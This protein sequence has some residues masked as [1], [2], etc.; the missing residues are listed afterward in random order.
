[1]LDIHD[2]LEGDIKVEL[3]DEQEL[4]VKGKIENK[5]NAS[6]AQFKKSFNL[7]QIGKKEDISAVISDDGILTITVPKEVRKFKSC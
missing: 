5:S 3:T 4:V 2:F 7:S 1:M 6:F